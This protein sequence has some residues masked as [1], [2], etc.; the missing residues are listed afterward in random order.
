MSTSGSPA[1]WKD[2]AR[3]GC[4]YDDHARALD[5]SR[6]PILLTERRDHVEYLA[7]CLRDLARH[8]I[9]L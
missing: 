6:L 8:V 2:S 9:V 5:E 3:R 1:S 4:Q 7:E